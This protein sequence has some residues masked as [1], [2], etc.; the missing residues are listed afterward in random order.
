VKA[1]LALVIAAGM[2]AVPSMASADGAKPNLATQFLTAADS[3]D[4]ATMMALGTDSVNDGGRKISFAE[5]LKKIEPCY[6]RRVYKNDNNGDV[7]AAWMCA[8][9][10][11]ASRVV[12]GA[13]SSS[14]DRIT[15]SVLREDRNKRPAP[16]RTGSAF[17]EAQK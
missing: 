2:V 16:P 6:L 10:E 9:S 13:L 8:E 3:N 11:E 15:V 17:A 1:R 7:L 14:A 4:F 5:F 12:M